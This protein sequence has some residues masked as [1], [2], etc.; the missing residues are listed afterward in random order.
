M[1]FLEALTVLV[2][3]TSGGVW[4]SGIGIWD[5]HGRGVL[6]WVFLSGNGV[7][8]LITMTL[9]GCCGTMACIFG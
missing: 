3:T 4:T 6:S 9:H 2:L 7:W 1:F 8:T 5:L